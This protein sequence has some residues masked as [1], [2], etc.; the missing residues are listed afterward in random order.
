M[1]S[2]DDLYLIEKAK[3][4]DYEAFEKLVSKYEAKVYTVAYRFFGNHEDACDLTQEVFIKVYKS[5]SDF[6][7]DSNFM[8]WLY[9]I[10][11]NACRDELRK[12]KSKCT[13][14]LDE[15]IKEDMTLL[16]SIPNNTLP[17][18]A[19]FERKEL[20]DQVQHCLNLMSDE[21]RLVLIMREI[22]GLSYDEIAASMKCSLGTV[23]SRLS[24]ARTIFRKKFSILMEHSESPIRQKKR[25]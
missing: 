2:I 16:S 19:E 18:D 23:K 14:S 10:T 11:A 8:T 21:H 17:P 7:G 22:Q 15:E 4:G 12:R 20:S 25:R 1:S 3:S 24:R 5:L 6:R 9:R 13:I